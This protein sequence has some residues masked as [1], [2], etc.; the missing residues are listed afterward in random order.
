MQ[1][2]WLLCKICWFPWRE[3]EQIGSS[4]SQMMGGR[5]ELHLKNKGLPIL[6]KQITWLTTKPFLTADLVEISMK[7]PPAKPFF[8]FVKVNLQEQKINR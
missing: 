5:K 4:I 6:W 2:K 8:K 7:K 3:L 1:I